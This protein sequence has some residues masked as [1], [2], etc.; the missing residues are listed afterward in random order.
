MRKVPDGIKKML[1]LRKLQSSC[2]EGRNALIQQIVNFLTASFVRVTTEELVQ[3][4][5]SLK[6]RGSR[7]TGRD[8]ERFPIE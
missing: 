4:D 6:G 7:D 8:L 1:I 2:L 5:Y 3:L